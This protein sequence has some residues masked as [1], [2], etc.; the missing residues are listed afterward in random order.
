[1]YNNIHDY[2]YALKRSFYHKIVAGIF[3]VIGIFVI[4]NL[5]LKFVL[6][7]VVINSD[8]MN[9]FFETKDCIFISPVY[10]K[11][12]QYKRG[13]IL[14]VSEELPEKH[15]FFKRVVDSVVGFVSFQNYFP[16]ETK[17]KDFSYVRRLIGLPGDTLYVENYVVKI[18]EPGS[19][20][21]LTEFELINYN[22]EIISKSDTTDK[23]DKTLGTPGNTEEIT[24]KENEYF[25]LSDNRIEC[26]DSRIWG[27]VLQ[28][29]I[30]GK[31]VLRYF[32]FNRFGKVK[33]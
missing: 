20:H 26:I 28:K 16:F 24:L 22:Y 1:M 9:P 23:I 15:S 33:K 30:H 31:V 21:F 10:S 13:D 5:L 29:Q 14:F 25:L 19:S 27:P 7:P 18:K 2:D 8:S 12:A 17:S 6:F 4:I 32:P 11:N 3:Y